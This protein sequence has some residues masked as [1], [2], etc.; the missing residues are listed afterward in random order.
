M[1]FRGA[2]VSHT[3]SNAAISQ[4]NSF[5]HS[6][7]KRVSRHHLP[8]VIAKTDSTGTSSG[9]AR[10]LHEVARRHCERPMAL[11]CNLNATT[12]GTGFIHA[13]RCS[14]VTVLVPCCGSRASHKNNE[15]LPISRS[16]TGWPLSPSIREV[17]QDLPMVFT[18]E[19]KVV[20][21]IIC[22]PLRGRIL[23]FQL[24]PAV[25]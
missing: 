10:P 24:R 6:W 4:L 21:T 8:Q 15:V 17:H 25:A 22:H 13:A 2:L 18:L 16:A 19:P 5:S 9:S 3:S 11:Q 7:R 1:L 12:V 14:H 23:A 20:V